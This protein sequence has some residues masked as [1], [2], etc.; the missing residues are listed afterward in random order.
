MTYYRVPAALRDTPCYKPNKTP[1]TPN[2]WY[3]IGNEL[4]TAA[5]CRR[6]NAPIEMLER[7][8]VK[9]NCLLF[10]LWCPFFKEG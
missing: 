3:L 2:G 6:M 4:L 7:I 1:R 8:E 9:K 5:E 10:R